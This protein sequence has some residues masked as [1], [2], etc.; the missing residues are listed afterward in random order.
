[1]LAAVP[2]HFAHHFYNGFSFMIGLGRHCWSQIRGKV[3]GQTSTPHTG[4]QRDC[5]SALQTASL[6]QAEPTEI[7]ER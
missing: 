5:P 6:P 7:S 3:R 1:M 2:L 4:I